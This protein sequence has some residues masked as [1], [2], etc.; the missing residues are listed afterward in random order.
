MTKTS[1]NHRGR[2]RPRRVAAAPSSPHQFR[3]TNEEWRLIG[4]RARQAGVSTSEWVRSTLLSVANSDTA[5]L[6]PSGLT[7]LQR[8]GDVASKF[9]LA[10]EEALPIAVE[11]LET[12]QGTGRLQAAVGAKSRRL[13]AENALGQ[14]YDLY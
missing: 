14:P 1:K 6:T 12:P 11:L 10:P 13:S 9:G 7:Q 3:C 4:K 5:R 8:I 2:G